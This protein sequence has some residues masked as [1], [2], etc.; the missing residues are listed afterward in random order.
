MQGYTR[1]TSGGANG[2][3]GQRTPCRTRTPRK[4]TR[5]RNQKAL[6]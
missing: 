5:V 1:K 2:R 3:S 4:S 6:K